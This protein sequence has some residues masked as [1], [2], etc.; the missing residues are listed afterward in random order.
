MYRLYLLSLI[1]CVYS[2]DNVSTVYSNVNNETFLNEIHEM[3]ADNNIDVL[4]NLSLNLISRE[5]NY[6]DVLNIKILSNGIYILRDIRY[7]NKS[8]EFKKYVIKLLIDIGNVKYVTQDLE[9]DFEYMILGL[10]ELILNHYNNDDNFLELFIYIQNMNNGFHIWS[11]RNINIYNSIMIFYNKL[12]NLYYENSSIRYRIDDSVI[13]ILNIALYYPYYYIRKDVIKENAY[14]Y[15]VK[16]ITVYE[17]KIFSKYRINP[18]KMPILCNKNLITLD[19]KLNNKYFI[20][21]TNNTN[22]NKLYAIKKEI[23]DTYK[24]F[25]NKFN[26]YVQYNSDI[27]HIYLFDTKDDYNKYKLK[28]K[29]RCINLYKNENFYQNLN[30]K[31][32]NYLIKK[33]FRNIPKWI[34]KGSLKFKGNYNS[35]YIS[36]NNYKY[37]STQYNI[38]YILSNNIER[39]YMI[40]CNFIFSK[41]RYL[42]NKIIS[43]NNYTDV[44]D[45]S[46]ETEYNKYKLIYYKIFENT[47]KVYEKRYINNLYL[48]HIY[49]MRDIFTKIGV[50]QFNLNN[51]VYNMTSNKLIRYNNTSNLQISENDYTLFLNCLS[52]YVLEKF[53]RYNNF[54]NDDIELFTVKYFD[55]QICYNTTMQYNSFNLLNII[56]KMKNNEMTV[57]L[58]DNFNYEQLKEIL[59]RLI[60][61]EKICNYT[62]KP[63]TPLLNLTKN[64]SDLI[65]DMSMPNAKI[66][67]DIL[68]NFNYIV[69]LNN[70]SLS[71]LLRTYKLYNNK[72]YYLCVSVVDDYVHSSN[73]NYYIIIFV[74]CSIILILL[75]AVLYIII[76]LYKYHGTYKLNSSNIIHSEYFM[77][78][79]E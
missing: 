71:Y 32:H 43:E 67:L 34:I 16:N 58:Y 57:L 24:N 70:H 39:E 17:E 10:Y 48:D 20:Y 63:Y 59:Y 21:Y 8:I 6:E 26:K 29:N 38:T 42:F 61:R 46:I 41:Y 51:D 4:F 2:D 37:Y 27:V 49:F 19:I 74:I 62:I 64:I 9:E 3:I 44:F 13:Q 31:I 40:V 65:Y 75:I 68:T 30:I 78:S 52:K 1:A 18:R 50:L 56:L 73:I 77:S 15:Y 5:Y 47:Y 55:S 28:C 54:S 14:I 66:H 7:N 25:L 23:L 69:D 35:Y 79:F 45:S 53:M 22:L 12:R 60:N 36:Y 76:I 11:N 72:Q 33:T